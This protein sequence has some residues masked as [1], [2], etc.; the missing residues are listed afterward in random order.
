[1]EILLLLL[2]FIAIMETRKDIR[3]NQKTKKDKE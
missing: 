2:I 3:D 1:M